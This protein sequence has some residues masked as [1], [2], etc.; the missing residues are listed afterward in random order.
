MSRHAEFIRGVMQETQ[1]YAAKFGCSL[2]DA[3]DDFEGDGPEG[4]W[5]LSRIERD[6]VAANLGICLG[7]GNAL[8]DKRKQWALEGTCE[9]ECQECYNGRTGY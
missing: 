5:G 7:C 9:A 8:S 4:S 2:L 3:L 6:E 1:E